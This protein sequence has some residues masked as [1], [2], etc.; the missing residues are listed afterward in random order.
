MTFAEVSSPIVEKFLEACGSL[1]EELE[2]DGSANFAEVFI[3]APNLR[4]LRWEPRSSHGKDSL[5][6]AATLSLSATHAKLQRFIVK[7][8]LESGK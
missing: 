1:V 7:G 2:F 4:D 5:T 6:I 3:H 8:I